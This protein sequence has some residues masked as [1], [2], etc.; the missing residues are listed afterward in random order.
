M[1]SSPSPT[2]QPPR[3]PASEQTPVKM[4]PIKRRAGE[5][6]F[7]LAIKGI[8]RPL[9]KGIYYLIRAIRSHRLATL[10]II[11]LL[12]ASVSVTNFL[13]VGYWPFGIGRDPYATVSTSGHTSNSDHIL[14]WLYALRDGDASKMSLIES[15]L[16]MTTPPDP[17]QLILA[18]SQPQ[19]HLTWKSI[20][21]AGSYTESDTTVDTFVAVEVTGS[22]PGGVVKGV[23]TFQF[24]IDPSSQGRILIIYTPQARAVQS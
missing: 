24:V 8:F 23:I 2:Q 20:N 4:T 14:N 10:L 6:A 17:T 21:F 9:F 13:T 15:E 12:A 22:G 16:T 11:V 19:G 7:A 5:S 3:L 1:I 18:F